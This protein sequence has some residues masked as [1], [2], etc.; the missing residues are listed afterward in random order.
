MK[1]LNQAGTPS[2]LGVSVQNDGVNFAI[3]SRNATR[4]RL[5]LF[6]N[7]QDSKASKIIDFDPKL[8]RTGDVWHVCLKAIKHGQLYAYRV[9]GPYDPKA[10]HR[11]NFNKLL[12]DP[13][14]TAITKLFPWDFD[15]ARGYNSSVPDSDLVLSTVDNAAASPK[16]VVTLEKYE[17]QA[18]RS[19]RQPWSKT[20]I[21]ETHLRGFSIHPSSGVEHPGT[22]QGL[23]EKIP[24]LKDL[25]VTAVEL[26]PYLNLMTAR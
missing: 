3:F 25:G 5:E 16:C 18:D 2:P 6:D 24:Y 12:V 13:C 20:I 21:Y 23:I 8:N 4:V 22:Y 26:L 19:P 15:L 17:W 14:A 10:G 11:F 9:D 7:P 1:N